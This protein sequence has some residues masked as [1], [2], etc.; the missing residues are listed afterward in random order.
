[1][2]LLGSAAA[3]GYQR[4]VSSERAETSGFREGR[5]VRAH[6]DSP[7]LPAS[8]APPGTEPLQRSVSEYNLAIVRDGIRGCVET[9]KKASP[10]FFIYLEKI[11]PL[12][13][14]LP[15]E[16][17]LKEIGE[18]YKLINECDFFTAELKTMDDLKKRIASSFLSYVEQQKTE[19]VKQLKTCFNRSSGE[20]DHCY[21]QLTGKI[22]QLFSQFTPPMQ[23]LLH[24]VGPTIV[25]GELDQGF[26]KNLTDQLRK[27]VSSEHQVRNQSAAVLSELEEFAR[28][29]RMIVERQGK[30]K[31]AVTQSYLERL[32]V[33]IDRS[34]RMSVADSRLH[35]EALEMI[36]SAMMDTMAISPG[37]DA[38]NYWHHMLFEA[39]LNL[40]FSSEFMAAYHHLISPLPPQKW[41]L[42]ELEGFITLLRYSGQSLG[43]CSQEFVSLLAKMDGTDNGQPAN[44]SVAAASGYNDEDDCRAVES[45][46]APGETEK[47]LTKEDRNKELGKFLHVVAL[48]ASGEFYYSNYDKSYS[49]WHIIVEMLLGQRAFTSPYARKAI[50][51]MVD[52]SKGGAKT[53]NLHFFDTT[54]NRANARRTLEQVMNQLRQKQPDKI[55]I[56][57][58]GYFSKVSIQLW[59]GGQI[60]H[61]CHVAAVTESGVPYDSMAMGAQILCGRELMKE[62]YTY[63][64]RAL[65]FRYYQPMKLVAP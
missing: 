24:N 35:L 28:I 9:G 1:M 6:S 17:S 33:M 16:E 61:T 53:A 46:E 45:D 14:G 22:K 59:K 39:V 36:D 2:D 50:R 31:P 30:H 55:D 5:D 12:L 54:G 64:D 63:R 49:D 25:S 48:E 8:Y 56:R 20:A 29:A 32:S 13:D 11:K 3:R 57:Q 34:V 40:R 42:E 18:L 7:G 21:E 10:E 38:E 58:H 15:T 26:K 44:T 19:L 52:L 51:F 37:P 4:T 23:A 47:G 41:G 27:N 62:L 60:C 65:E 43:Y